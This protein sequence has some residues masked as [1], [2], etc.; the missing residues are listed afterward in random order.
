MKKHFSLFLGLSFF[1]LLSL[2]SSSFAPE[3]IDDKNT[4][5]PNTVSPSTL[6]FNVDAGNSLTETIKIS[7]F[8]DKKQKYKVVYSDFK[9][10]KKGK[11]E[12]QEAGTNENSLKTF[13]EISP[14]FVEIDPGSSMEVTLTVSI[15]E[16]K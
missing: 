2:H 3:E 16:K 5:S 13:L 1:V 11:S 8:T 15:P 6:Q 12:F 7:N 9:I 10:D 4:Q 14:E